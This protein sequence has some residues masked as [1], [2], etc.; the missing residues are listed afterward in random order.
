[1]I[2]D[3]ENLVYLSRKVFFKFSDALAPIGLALLRDEFDVE[4]GSLAGAIVLARSDSTH[5]AG[6]H[7]RH[8]V[9]INGRRVTKY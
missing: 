1:M 7:V 4:E 9:L 6:R 8:Q 3:C 2:I 5:N